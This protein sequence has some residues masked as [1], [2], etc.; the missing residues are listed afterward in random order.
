MADVVGWA[1]LMDGNMTTAVYTMFNT[2]WSAGGTTGWFIVILF[3]VYQAMLF[4]KTKNLMLCW[5]TGIM[6]ASLWG[7]TLFV[8]AISLQF[9]WFLL[10]LE[11]GGILY[12]IVF[13]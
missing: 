1:E 6:F 13:K 12:L 10:V 4:M 3:F 5:V 8:E 9:M 2:S 11:L 7:T